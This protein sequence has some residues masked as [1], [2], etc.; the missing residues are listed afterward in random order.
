MVVVV[1]LAE[2]FDDCVALG[3]IFR[4]WR[5]FWTCFLHF[6]VRLWTTAETVGL[7][8]GTKPNEFG[9]RCVAVLRLHFAQDAMIFSAVEWM[10]LLKFACVIQV[11]GLGHVLVE[12]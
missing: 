12:V 1:L 4:D 9:W 10:V 3:E 5:V 2:A 7:H 11:S 6:L 8:F